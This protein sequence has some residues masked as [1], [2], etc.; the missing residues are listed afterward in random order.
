MPSA[1]AIP[2]TLPAMSLCPRVLLIDDESDLHELFADVL[3]REVRCRLL[4]ATSVAEARAILESQ[5]VELVVID[6]HLPD[7]DGLSLL[8]TIR[9]AQPF[10]GAIVITGKPS[11]DG[12]ISALRCGATD[13]L[14]K[15]F[16]ADQ[17]VER[18]R[19]ALN[20]QQLEAK[21]ERRLG[22]LRIAVRRLNDA[23]RTVAKKV[24]LLCND[25]IG[26]Y[27]ELSR[28]LDVVRTQEGFRKYLRE[29][30]DLE[31]LL[32]HTMDWIL[33]QA[34]Y[35][36]VAVWL[37]GDDQD[38]Q[39]G[40][41]MKYTIPGESALTDA[42][43]GGIIPLAARDGF[44]H[45]GTDEAGDVLT[46]RELEHLSGQTVMAV[47][48]TYL[49]ESL[50][51]VVLFRS[52][53]TPFGD[54][55]A[56]MLKTI[57]PLFAVALASVVRRESDAEMSEDSPT[58]EN[59]GDSPDRFGDSFDSFDQTDDVPPSEGSGGRKRRRDKTSDADWWKRGESPPF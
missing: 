12:A 1:T 4:R 30:R 49:G 16:S 40:A 34:G 42:M 45:L 13:F 28:Q 47:N 11:V 54:E 29:A 38:Y 59:D 17:L 52:G 22:R 26:A 18:I 55:D 23:R 3:G 32:C 6:V 14:P 8:Q 53:K 10:A 33:R 56:A 50:A 57:S 9:K 39:L 5:P 48:C 43:R 44:V 2:T 25:L 27:G 37:A 41:Y 21:N 20:R 58:D 7:G 19:R 31:Q 36:N 35:C 46:P 15:P 51:T 24:D